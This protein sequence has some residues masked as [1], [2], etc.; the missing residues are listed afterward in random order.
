FESN[1]IPTNQQKGLPVGAVSIFTGLNVPDNWLR[2]DGSNIS[3]TTYSKLFYVIG[4]LYGDG[5]YVNTFTLPDFRG[6]FPFGINNRQKSSFNSGGE[7]KHTLT[8]DELPI[9]RH[10][11]GTFQLTRAGQHTHNYTDPGHN[12]GGSTGEAF[13]SNGQYWLDYHGGGAGLGQHTHSIPV[14]KTGITIQSNGEHSHALRG[15]SGAIGKGKAFSLIPP[16]Q[17]IDFIILYQ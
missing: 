1:A 15:S 2:C 11:T 3:R 9:H 12:H 7:S 10:D 6:R 5:D 13:V 16:F 4:T 14:G 8:E 17:I